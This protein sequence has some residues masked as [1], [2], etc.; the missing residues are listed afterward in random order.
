MARIKKRRDPTHDH[1]GG[2]CGR[3]SHGSLHENKKMV[4]QRSN[5]QGTWLPFVVI[6]PNSNTLTHTPHTHTHKTAMPHQQDTKP[7]TPGANSIALQGNSNEQ[8]PRYNRNN[9]NGGVTYSHN[10]QRLMRLGRKR[11]LVCQA[12][13]IYDTFVFRRRKSIDVQNYIAR[14]GIYFQRASGH[15][16]S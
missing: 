2:I 9:A 5:P 4:A 6:A 8:T 15:R 3:Q 14:V 10:Y 11:T 7:L 1:Q 12:I 16:K 13:N